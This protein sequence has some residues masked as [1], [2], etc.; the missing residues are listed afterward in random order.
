MNKEAF[1]LALGERLSELPWDEVDERLNFYLEMIDDRMEEGL[2]EEEAVAAVGSVDE[3]VSQILAD[4]PLSTLMRKKLKPKHRLGTGATV[5]LILGSP[6][7]LPLLI[8][9]AAV[10]LSLYIALW[11]VVISLWAV[12]VSLLGCALGCLVAGIALAAK[13]DAVTGL[14]LAGF[15]LICA[16]LSIFAFFGCKAVTIGTAQIARHFFIGIKKRLAG[17]EAAV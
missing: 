11:A 5:L 8:A 14:A 4:I 6:V 1:I 13:S 10:V 15:G 2:S 17:K 16:G 12:F 9:G 3:I 7:W